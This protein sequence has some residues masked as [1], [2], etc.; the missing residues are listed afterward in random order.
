MSATRVI[1]VEDEPLF[2]ELLRSQLSN[3]P[4]IEV[5]GEAETGEFAIE[6]AKELKPEVMLMDIELGE[7][8]T[9][10]QAG[11]AIKLHR[12]TTG[13]VLLSNHRAKQF[14]VTSA[15]WSYLIKRNVRDIGTVARAIKGAAW[16][17]IVIDPFVTDVLKPR[18]DTALAKLTMEELKVLELVAQGFSDAAISK[19]MIV[20]EGKVRSYFSSVVVKLEIKP[21]GQIDPRVAAVRAYLEQTRD[22]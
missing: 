21:D 15:G 16:G 7:G 3:D 8:I 17:M 10:I 13:I 18:E 2:R 22:N 11:Y 1:V 5:V 19:Q 6:L 12:P 14:I 9:G 20:S 4:E